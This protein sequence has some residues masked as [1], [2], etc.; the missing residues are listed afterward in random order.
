MTMTTAL[1]G[2]SFL[3]EID[4]TTQEWEELLTLS[5]ELKAAKKQGRETQHLKG[6]NLALIFEK[7]STRTRCA[8]EVAAYDQGAN[9]T[10]LDPGGSQI[11]HKESMKDTARVLGRMYDGIEYRGSSTRSSRSSRS[12]AACGLERTDRRGH[13][14]HVPVR[15]ADHARARAGAGRSVAFALPGRRPQ[16]RRQ[17]A[18]RRRRDVGL[19]RPHR[20]ARA[21]VA[22]AG[23]RRPGARDRGDDG[24]TGDVDEQTWRR[25]RR[26]AVL[27]TDV[28]VSM[29]SARRLEGAHRAD[30]GTTR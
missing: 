18:A 3:K 26:R 22:Q 10:Y 21:A 4:L 20:R 12:T 13:P 16:Q 17:L 15:R 24:C 29:A 8:F 19:R 30:S 9:V 28:W 14:T 11:G 25:G 5:A 7:T 1:R 2:R 23:G 6:K 27:Y